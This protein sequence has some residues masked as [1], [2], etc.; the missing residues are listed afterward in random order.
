MFD[1]EI[2]RLQ[3]MVDETDN[4]VFF[5][6]AGVVYGGAGYRI[7]AAWT[8]CTIRLTPIRRRRFSVTAFILKIRKSLPFLP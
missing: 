6:G 8:D 3:E 1:K 4:M 7:S 2:A 5:G